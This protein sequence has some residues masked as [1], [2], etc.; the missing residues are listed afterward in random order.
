MSPAAVVSSPAVTGE[1]YG[2]S[3]RRLLDLNK[4]NRDE[5]R[6]FNHRGTRRAPRVNVFEELDTLF[7]QPRDRRGQVRSAERPV[8]HELAASTDETV[9]R[10]RTNRDS[11]IVEHDRAARLTHH[12]RLPFGGPRQW[13]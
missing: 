3:Q 10:P 11:N 4:L 13:P 1:M 7:L 5:V 8:I 12:A 9:A 2:N 6:P